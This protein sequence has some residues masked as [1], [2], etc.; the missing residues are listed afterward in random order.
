VLEAQLMMGKSDFRKF[1]L[2]MMLILTELT[3]YYF[4]I[5]CAC[6]KS[7]NQKLA[8]VQELEGLIPD[9]AEKVASE[10]QLKPSAP[11]STRTSKT[12]QIVEFDA[13]LDD[14]EYYEPRATQ[15]GK[16]RVHLSLECVLT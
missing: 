16:V 15:G 4:E 6:N 7:T 13:D 9:W 14:D 8:G 3:L 12:P 2:S 11:P 5:I 10:A 1:L